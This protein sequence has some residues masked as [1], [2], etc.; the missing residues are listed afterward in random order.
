MATVPAVSG[1]CLPANVHTPPLL[2]AMITAV[3]VGPC[4]SSPEPGLQP[5]TIGLRSQLDAVS[6]SLTSTEQP[7]GS[8]TPR[9][10]TLRMSNPPVAEIAQPNCSAPFALEICTPSDRA[11]ELQ[12]AVRARDLHAVYHRAEAVL[13]RLALDRESVH[14]A[15][16][17]AQVLDAHAGADV[18]RLRAGDGDGLG[19]VVGLVQPARD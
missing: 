5:C 6:C 1:A 9:T 18:R 16:R 8:A 2:P 19:V 12:R 4:H 7:S 3:F 11:A 10:F 17:R 13:Q 15:G 14:A